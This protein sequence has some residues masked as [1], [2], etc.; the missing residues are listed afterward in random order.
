MAIYSI[1]GGTATNN[2]TITVGESDVVNKLYSIGMGAGYENSDTGNV[3]N[4]GT[5]NV[6]GKKQ[7][8]NVC[9]WKRK[10]CDK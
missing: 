10:Y 6:N 4:K 5:I 3:V 2:A 9:K 7:Y 1:K 8:W